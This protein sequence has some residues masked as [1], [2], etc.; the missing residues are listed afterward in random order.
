MLSPKHPHVS[1]WS[2]KR[3][4]QLQSW[5]AF[6]NWTQIC[7][8]D[9]TLERRGI[10]VKLWV[11][12]LKVESGLALSGITSP[13]LRVWKVNCRFRCTTHWSQWSFF[14]VVKILAHYFHHRSI[15]LPFM[16]IAE[17]TMQQV[18]K[19]TCQNGS[20]PLFVRVLSFLFWFGIYGV[21]HCSIYYIWLSDWH[22]ISCMLKAKCLT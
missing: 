22:S 15:L 2:P 14:G 19:V 10:Y 3:V 9:L 18:N 5:T 21:V 20:K 11:L 16:Y 17:A 4:L 8:M 7:R 6:R 13:H 1:C 12:S